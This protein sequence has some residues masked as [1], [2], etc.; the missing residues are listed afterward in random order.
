MFTSKGLTWAPVLDSGRDVLTVL[1]VVSASDLVRFRAQ[2]E[3]PD[4]VR[5]WQLC[6]YK[7]ISVTADTPISEVA[8]LMVER[9]IHHVVVTKDDGIVGVVSSLDFVRTF[10]RP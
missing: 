3:D 2:A 9:K 6:T 10:V 5:A 1:G 8:R 4:S 7:P